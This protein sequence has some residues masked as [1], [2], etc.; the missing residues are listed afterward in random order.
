[1]N[2]K[3]RTNDDDLFGHSEDDISI[4]DVTMTKRVHGWHQFSVNAEIS[5]DKAV[6]LQMALGYHPAGYS[7]SNHEV[8]DGKTTWRCFDSCD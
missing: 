6:E 4:N 2:M 3:S 8:K 1:M 7:F 5:R